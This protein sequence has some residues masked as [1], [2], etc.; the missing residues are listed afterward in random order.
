M[1]T[2]LE[3]LL[4]LELAYSKLTRNINVAFNWKKTKKALPFYIYVAANRP[5]MVLVP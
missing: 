1:I 3:K 4:D 2:I 5:G